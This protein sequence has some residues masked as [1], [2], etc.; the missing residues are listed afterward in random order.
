MKIL[1][2]LTIIF[3]AL[4]F[5]HL[6]FAIV[7]RISLYPKYIED[8]NEGCLF[9]GSILLLA[10]ICPFIAL[11]S[12]KYIYSKEFWIRFINNDIQ[13]SG[14]LLGDICAKFIT[15]CLFMT[16][17]S[18][19]ENILDIGNIEY[20]FSTFFQIGLNNSSEFENNIDGLQI[21]HHYYWKILLIIFGSL[22][23]GLVAICLLSVP[24]ICTY[25]MSNAV[26]ESCFPWA[27]RNNFNDI[28]NNTINNISEK[29][30]G[31]LNFI[32]Q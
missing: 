26:I 2:I 14:E 19:I 31:T 10:E 25:I 3:F 21:L 5:V 4:F 6:A 8:S 20:N 32:K 11:F 22:L 12:N 24:A 13:F 28:E 9:L 1:N 29:N 7:L 30:Y 18:S 15:F 23:L 16:A 27:I 17:W